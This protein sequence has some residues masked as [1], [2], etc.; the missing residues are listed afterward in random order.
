MRITLILCGFIPL[1]GCT[2]TDPMTRPG[3]WHPTGANDANL[4]AMIANP[5]DLVI[6]ASSPGADG[7]VAAAAVQRYRTGKVKAL[8]DSGVA[9]VSAVSS[10]APSGAAASTN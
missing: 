8:P 10:G 2:A 7:D 5:H 9:Q 6:G 3:I 1:L 4:R